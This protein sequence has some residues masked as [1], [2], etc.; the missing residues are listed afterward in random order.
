MKDAY[1]I[2]IY[3]TKE[4]FEDIAVLDDIYPNLNRIF[5]ES[6]VFILDMTE[7]ELDKSLD[8]IESDFAVFCNSH[9]IKTTAQVSV[10]NNMLSNKDELIKNCRSLFIMDIDEQEAR[11]I[12]EEYGVLVLSKNNIDDNI[13]NQKFWR[14]FFIKDTTIQGDAITEWIDALK[15]MSWLPTNSLVISDNYLFTGAYL[16]DC[17]ENVKGLLDAILPHNL[18]VDFHILISTK[19]PVCSELKRNQ[20]VG[21]IKSYIKSKRDYDIKLEF[22]FCESLHQR[23][24]ITNYNIMI[25]DK[26][27]VNFSNLKK[28][29]IDN[30]PTYA[31]TVFQ[32]ITNSIGDTEYGMASIDL[33]NIYKI[34]EKVKEMNVN[35]I[36]DYTKRIVGNCS[37]NKTINNRLLIARV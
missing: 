24:V 28:K 20:I 25:G 14:H 36:N 6:A 18:G 35:G 3:L 33:E 8:N 1:K 19:H 16:E 34:S 30:N 21:E 11:K 29:I 22:I 4:S 17:V 23:K 15:D 10:L 13:F 2:K 27:F 31:C 9:N 5:R 12:Q 32:N 7:D 37:R 26:G